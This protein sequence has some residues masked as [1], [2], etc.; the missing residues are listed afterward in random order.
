[1]KIY[2]AFG[3]FF[4]YVLRRFLTGITARH[5]RKSASN[6]PEVGSMFISE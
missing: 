6:Q 3:P 4:L 1:M 2:A 5:V